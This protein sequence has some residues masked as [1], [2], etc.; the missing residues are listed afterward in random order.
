LKK[1][2]YY[3]EKPRLAAG[4]FCSSQ[5]EC[6][7]IPRKLSVDPFPES[8]TDCG[9]CSENEGGIEKLTESVCEEKVHI[10]LLL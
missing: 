10:L 6:L 2:L 5:A 4:F 1:Y 9:T 3:K 7:L 8:R